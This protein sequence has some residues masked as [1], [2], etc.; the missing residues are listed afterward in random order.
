[1]PAGR[2]TARLSRSAG[3][4]MRYRWIPGTTMHPTRCATDFAKHA[5]GV[6]ALASRANQRAGHPPRGG[7][8]SASY[9]RSD[10]PDPRRSGRGPGVG[11]L[12]QSDDPRASVGQPESNWTIGP[13]QLDRTD[14]PNLQCGVRRPGSNTKTCL[15]RRTLDSERRTNAKG[16]RMKRRS[17]RS[18]CGLLLDA[19]TTARKLIDARGKVA[20]MHAIDGLTI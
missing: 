15:R 16:S 9:S 2:P 13:V 6:G 8:Q 3:S 1:M 18:C 7:A 10:L 5:A 20:A 14:A 11:R 4:G 12:V 17:G 19:I